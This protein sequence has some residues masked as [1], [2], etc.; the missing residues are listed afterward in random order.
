MDNNN[1]SSHTPSLSREAVADMEKRFSEIE[2]GLRS[3]ALGLRE[4]RI[5][6]SK[7]DFVTLVGGLEKTI[8]G[9]GRA[10]D[11]LRIDI[12]EV[13]PI[14]L[15]V[16]DALGANDDSRLADILENALLPVISAWS[17]SFRNTFPPP[18]R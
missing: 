6:Q 18:R 11:V 9:V 16:N 10:A 3:C 2:K 17:A 14:L 15:S 8:M 13:T 4:G 1:A 7:L 5:E 12:R